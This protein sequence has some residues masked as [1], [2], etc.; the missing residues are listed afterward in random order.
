MRDA[1]VG[2]AP[3]CSPSYLFILLFYLYKDVAHLVPV[4]HDQLNPFDRNLIEKKRK[5]LFRKINKMIFFLFS[6]EI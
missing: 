3:W 1:G 4:P 6:Y 5:N 2:H